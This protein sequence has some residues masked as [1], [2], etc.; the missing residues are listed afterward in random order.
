LSSVVLPLPVPPITATVFAG[1]AVR[2]MPLSTGFLGPGMRIDV[3]QLQVPAHPGDR[4]GDPDSTTLLSVSSTSEIRSAETSARGTI[5]NMKV[6]IM[7]DIRI[8][9][10]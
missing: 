8:C 9:I 1:P 2:S 4:D 10:R 5:M 7:T 3:V 6:A